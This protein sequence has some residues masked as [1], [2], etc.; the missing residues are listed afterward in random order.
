MVKFTPITMFNWSIML[1]RQERLDFFPMAIPKYHLMLRTAPTLFKKSSHVAISIEYWEQ[2]EACATTFL[3]I[4]FISKCNVSISLGF[5]HSSLTT[6]QTCNLLKWKWIL[7]PK[8][9]GKKNWSSKKGKTPTTPISGA[10]EVI[11]KC[12][13]LITITLT[14]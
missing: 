4:P 5:W 14:N 11:E 1:Q 12:E 3:I 7:I 2:F 8:R 13:Q 10:K 9:I 6:T